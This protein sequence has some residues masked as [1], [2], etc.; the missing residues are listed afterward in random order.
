[1]IA[2]YTLAISG[3]ETCSSHFE[4]L[5]GK[6]RTGTKRR[7]QSCLHETA[8]GHGACFVEEIDCEKAAE[9]SDGAREYWWHWECGS[10]CLCFSGCI[11]LIILFSSGGQVELG[12]LANLVLPKAIGREGRG[13][14]PLL[15]RSY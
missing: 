8:G 13:S 3:H 4:F 1:M 6:K 14:H 11:E 12:S 9:M 2:S 15:G 5:V 7:K 10:S